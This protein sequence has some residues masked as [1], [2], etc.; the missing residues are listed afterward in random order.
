MNAAKS[1][2]WDAAARPTGNYLNVGTVSKTRFGSRCNGYRAPDTEF[3]LSLLQIVNNSLCLHDAD[4]L[5]FE[6]LHLEFTDVRDGPFL[7]QPP[8]W[9]IVQVLET[10]DRPEARTR[11]TKYLSQ[12]ELTELRRPHLDLLDSGWVRPSTWGDATSAVFALQSDGSWRKCY[13]YRG[14][15]A[16]TGPLVEPVPHVL[17][18]SGAC[19]D[20][21]DLT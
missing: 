14:L 21:S 18:R 7:A 11:P 1:A 8:D 15:S 3:E 10:G 12:D 2:C 17:E 6:T 9:G 16:I 19:C 5:G 4:N 20:L 13:D